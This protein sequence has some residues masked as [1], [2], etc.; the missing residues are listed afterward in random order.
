VSTAETGS[1]E[2]TM[3]PDPHD[4]EHAPDPQAV[5]DALGDE[6]CRAIV[7]ELTEP[8]TASELSERCDV[9]LSTTYRKLETLTDAGLLAERTEVRSDGHHTT[10]YARAFENVSIG[11]AEDGSLTLSVAR[12]PEGAEDRLARLWSEVR[13]ET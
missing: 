10:Q 1:E 2:P 8:L 9:P 11:V 12:P 13:K 5:L 7:G 4:D 6:A 3:V